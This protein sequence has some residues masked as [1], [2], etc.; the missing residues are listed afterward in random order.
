[1][2][3]IC[4]LRIVVETQCIVTFTIYIRAQFHMPSFS[5]TLIVEIEREGNEDI[6]P[7]TMLLLYILQIK[8][9]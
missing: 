6:R 8:L 9:L 2:F 3:V 7:F 5:G 4:N 1:M